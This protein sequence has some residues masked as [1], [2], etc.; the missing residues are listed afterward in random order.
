[1]SH[2]VSSEAEIRPAFGGEEGLGLGL[3]FGGG[4]T[5]MD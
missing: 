5:D 1:M 2:P 4:I 3:G